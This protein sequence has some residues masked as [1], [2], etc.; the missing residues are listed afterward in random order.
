MLELFIALVIGLAIGTAD[1]PPSHEFHRHSGAALITIED[2]QPEQDV[3]VESLTGDVYL[4]D[5]K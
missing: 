2:H 4:V 3:F 1:K 5:K